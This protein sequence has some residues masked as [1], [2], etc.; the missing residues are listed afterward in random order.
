MDG[1]EVDLPGEET[2]LSFAYKPIMSD[3]GL[4]QYADNVTSEQYARYSKISENEFRFIGY[5]HEK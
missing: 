4:Q 3:A 1:Q 5:F 2:T